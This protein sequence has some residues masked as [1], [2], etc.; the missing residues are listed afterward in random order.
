MYGKSI[1]P[2]SS[3]LGTEANEG[4][5]IVGNIFRTKKVCIDHPRGGSGGLGVAVVDYLGCFCQEPPW[6]VRAKSLSG[7]D[8]DILA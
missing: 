2:V 7:M 4:I 1:V 3:R 6:L 8:T 5:W